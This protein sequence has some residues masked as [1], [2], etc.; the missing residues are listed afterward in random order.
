MPTERTRPRKGPKIQSGGRCQF[1]GRKRHNWFQRRPAQAIRSAFTKQLFTPRH[2]FRWKTTPRASHVKRRIASAGSIQFVH[3]DWGQPTG[4]LRTKEGRIFPAG[5]QGSVTLP[6]CEFRFPSSIA[7]YP[8]GPALHRRGTDRLP[9][10]RSSTKGR[11]PSQRFEKPHHR[12][13]FREFPLHRHP[14]HQ[15]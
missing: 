15:K 1:V 12:T 3:S 11:M 9:P 5:R 14:P 8:T 4:I 6:E 7:K 10:S 13:L 2:E